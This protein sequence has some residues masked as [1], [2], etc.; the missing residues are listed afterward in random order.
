[1]LRRIEGRQEFIVLLKLSGWIVSDIL[2]LAL[3]SRLGGAVDFFIRD[4]IKIL[5]LLFGMIFIIGVLRTWLP[6]RK[7]KAWMTGRG[8]LGYLGASIFGAV[9]P[10]CSCSSIPVFIGF[11]KAGIPLGVAFSFLITSPLVNEYLVI[12]MLGFFGWRVTILYVASGILLG[13]LAGLILGR[14]K[15][16]KHLEKDL[17]GDWNVGE[18]DEDTQSFRD[19]LK[20]GFHE[21]T[22]ITRKIWIWVL[23]GVGIGAGIHNYVPQEAIRSTLGSA[24]IFSVPLATLVGVP[25]YGS[26][27]AMVPIALV[28][29]QKGVPLGT[30][31]AFM[32][33]AAAL[34]L[35]EA[36]M[37][38]R[39]MKLPLILIFF[40]V[41]TLGIIFIGYLFNAL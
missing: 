22:S 20:F 39:V 6:Q 28:L 11:V 12:L 7:V 36:V 16:E 35:P 40:G 25:I 5:L 4:S 30:A 24:G 31:L 10:F 38:R 21:A 41:T 29:F 14:L 17:V 8:I 18:E 3:D 19:R 34:S 9:T 15:L 13:M 23:V 2:G 27:A 26:C 33:A 1:M 32:M 37:L